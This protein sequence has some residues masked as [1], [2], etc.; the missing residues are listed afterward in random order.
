MV[1][2]SVFT[3]GVLLRFFCEAV[4]FSLGLSGMSL[5][6]EQLSEIKAF[7]EGRNVFVCLPT[8][9]GKSLCYQTLPFVMEHELG[10]DRAVITVSL[11]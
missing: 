3:S 6:E 2:T 5:K 11:Y 4:S 9:Y 8:G 1:I 7:Y 10:G